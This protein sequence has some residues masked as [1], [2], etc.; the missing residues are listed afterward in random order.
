MGTHIYQGNHVTLVTRLLTCLHIKVFVVCLFVC[1][2]L[3]VCGG[4][5]GAILTKIGLYWQILVKKPQHKFVLTSTGLRLSCSMWT[6]I[7][8][9]MDG[10]Q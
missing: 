7:C 9:H 5:G 4:G 8:G 10:Q 2:L 3:R 1:V 6:D